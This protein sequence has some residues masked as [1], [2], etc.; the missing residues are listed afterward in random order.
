LRKAQ[1]NIWFSR[2]LAVFLGII[3]PL[4]ETIRRWSTWRE[5]P[6]AFFDDF[7]LGGQKFLAAGWGFMCG[8]VYPSFFFQLERMRAGEIDPAP[9]SSEW[10]AVI[11]GIGFALAIIGL[12]T[13]LRK[14]SIE[15]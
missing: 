4:L 14:V 12:I 9:V 15:K 10:V 8:M 5:A 11:K 13:S 6:A 3:T 1:V 7:I 2:N